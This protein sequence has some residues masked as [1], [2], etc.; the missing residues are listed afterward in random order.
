MIDIKEKIK[1]TDSKVYFNK[2][3]IALIIVT[4]LFVYANFINPFVQSQIKKFN[5]YDIKTKQKISKNINERN[6][7]K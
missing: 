6:Y 1:D 4:V 3:R 7:L 5:Q 2:E